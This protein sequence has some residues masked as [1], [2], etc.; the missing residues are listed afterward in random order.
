MCTCASLTG[1]CLQSYY[2]KDSE[3]AAWFRQLSPLVDFSFLQFTHENLPSGS[4]GANY[5]NGG[6]GIETTDRRM[7]L[8]KDDLYS[9]QFVSALRR[10]REDGRPLLRLFQQE[11]L[12]DKLGYVEENK[13]ATVQNIQTDSLQE[14]R[15]QAEDELRHIKQ[16]F[17]A[18]KQKQRYL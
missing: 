17:A 3:T 6:L 7:G 9:V 18:E 1:H 13:S 12:Q 14:Y 16:I 4:C 10:S 8:T 5:A 2:A 15:T 11:C